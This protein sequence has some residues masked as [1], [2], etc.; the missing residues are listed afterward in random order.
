[1]R[2]AG[3][4]IETILPA[5]H[6]HM[7]RYGRFWMVIGV[8]VAVGGVGVYMLIA[9]PS[10]FVRETIVVVP[11]GSSVEAAAAKLYEAEVIARPIVLEMLLRISGSSVR[12]G[13]YR[14]SEPENLLAIAK[15]LATGESGIPPVRVT[16]VE[17]TTIREMAVLVEE[18]FPGIT[19]DAFLSAAGPHEGYLFPDT[20]VFSPDADA[21]TVIEAL[22]ANF[23]KRIEP[24]RDDIAASGH[25]LTEILT[26]ASIIEKEVHIPADR[27][28]VSG[29][30]WNRLS[31][32]MPLQVDAVF[33]Y[34]FSRPTYS[35]SLDDLKI[36]SP[37]NTYRYKGLPPG[38][39]NNPG[40]DAIAAALEPA[41]TKYLYYLSDRSGVT[42]YAT[43]YEGHLANQR[44]Y[45]K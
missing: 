30:L 41:K 23:T 42:H 38:P 28:I 20:Y 35:P 15:R 6:M 19:R 45:L 29:I 31:R 10:D 32:G 26:M 5:L 43:T 36:D 33:G 13:T 24:Y 7:L 40:L 2:A 18:S 4:F 21:E 37:Y 1:M 25:T 17:G 8:A 3:D 22:R 14:F 16:F 11:R 9:P 44:K 12:A 27:R 39:I 34:I